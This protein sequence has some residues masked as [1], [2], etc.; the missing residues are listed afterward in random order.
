[1][2]SE[3]EIGPS[4]RPATLLGPVGWCA[5]RPMDVVFLLHG[6]SANALAQDFL[7][8]LGRQVE[9]LDFVLV[10][11]NG[12]IDLSGRRFWNGPPGCCDFY[13]S[14]VDDVGYLHSLIEEIDSFATINNDKVYFTGHS[15]G[16]FMSYR[17]ACELPERVRAIVSLA[18][19]GYPNEGDCSPEQPVSVL[20]IHGMLDSTIPYAGSFNYPGAVELT[21]RW[22][23]RAGCNANN[24]SEAAEL[25]LT[26]TQSGTDTEVLNFA[27]E[28]TA[29]H[30]ASL[31]SLPLGGHVPILNAQFAPLIMD[32]L[33]T[34]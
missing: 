27:S 24:P 8:G 1:M 3:L 9:E 17:M 29:G 23:R 32:W 22:A 25:N 13:N 11:P 2:G 18:G 28:C 16:G 10:L 4:D 33:R 15:N 21:E 19:S 5:N 7:F 34:H 12:T 14:G 30:R 20:Q 31:W 6:Y 26:R